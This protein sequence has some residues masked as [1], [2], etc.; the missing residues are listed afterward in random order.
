[1]NQHLYTCLLYD[2]KAQEAAQFYGKTI[3]TFEVLSQN[4][5]LVDF[6]LCGSRLMT[7]NAGPNFKFT[8]AISLF[9]LC[10]TVEETDRLYH[11]LIEGG[12][13]LMPID[14]YD[15]SPRYGWLQDK[16]GLTWQVMYTE[17]AGTK[18]RIFPSMLFTGSNFG[19]ASEAM[20]FYVDVFKGNIQSSSLYPEQSPF[21]GKLLYAE[22]MLKDQLLAMMDGPGEHAFSF[23]EA[24]SLVVTCNNQEETDFYWDALIA[25]GGEESRCGWLKDAYGVSWQIVP[26]KLLELVN[27]KNPE[28]SRYAFEAMLK[29]N[30]IVILGLQKPKSN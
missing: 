15:W 11:V 7:L 6:T 5:M 25:N 13:A 28:V 22:C 2:G 4:K 12:K 16:Y 9:L 20:A 30:K 24:V 26:K 14:T 1:M 8:P 27:H 10:N 19:K 21:P 17:D 3:G 23:S 18:P 29:M